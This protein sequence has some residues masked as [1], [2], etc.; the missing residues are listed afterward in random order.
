ME[1]T[2][3]TVAYIITKRSAAFPPSAA[4]DQVL[5]ELS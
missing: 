2:H 5:G 3:V 4:Q 1:T